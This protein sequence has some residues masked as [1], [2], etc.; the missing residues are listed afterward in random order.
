MTTRTALA[1][2]AARLARAAGLEVTPLADGQH[3]VTGGAASHVVSA[4]G[5]DCTD[6]GVRGAPCKHQLAVRLAGLDPDLQ[7]AIRALAG[8]ARI[9]R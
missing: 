3:R 8:Q 7:A 5:C 1:P 2:L 6:Y 9:T 4:A